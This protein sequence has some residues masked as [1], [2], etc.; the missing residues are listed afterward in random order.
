MYGR[1]DILEVQADKIAYIDN[2]K[3][4][5]PLKKRSRLDKKS[6]DESTNLDQFSHASEQWRM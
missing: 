3:G 2:Y 4:K 5:G 1:N 6:N